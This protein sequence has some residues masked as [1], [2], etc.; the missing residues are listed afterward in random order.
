MD[1]IDR[2]ISDIL[3]HDGRRPNAEI[4]QSVGVSVSTA[5]ERIRKLSVAGAITATRAVL[6]PYSYGVG[7]CAFVMMDVSHEHEGAARSA[8]TDFEEVQEMHHVSGAHSYLL[9][10]RVADTRAM[11]RFL[12]DKLK[13]LA[14]ITRTETVFALDTVKETSALKID[15]PDGVRS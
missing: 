2:K 9:K 3:Q 12:Q 11:Q 15:N 10:V 8:I 4:A 6:D 1:D 13:P 7:L 5:N 14:G